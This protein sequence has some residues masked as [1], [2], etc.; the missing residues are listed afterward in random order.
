M[1]L[2]VATQESIAAP[3]KLNL[4]DYQHVTS[5]LSRIQVC[6][7]L[8]SWWFLVLFCLSWFFSPRMIFC[9]VFFFI[10]HIS[11]HKG[12]TADSTTCS[13]WGSGGGWLCCP[14]VKIIVT[15]IIINMMIISRWKWRLDDVECKN[16]WKKTIVSKIIFRDVVSNGVGGTEYAQPMIE[17][18]RGQIMVSEIWWSGISP[19]CPSFDIL[20][21]DL[22]SMC[23]WI[24]DDLSTL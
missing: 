16:Q 9:L 17:G 15:M 12:E 19:S 10:P 21:Y 22:W 6:L 8:I 4:Q 18:G 3:G 13:R 11:C 14:E 7:R 1:T 23:Y 5:A 2:H 20:L 24:H